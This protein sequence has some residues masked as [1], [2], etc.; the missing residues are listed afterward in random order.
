MPS[1]RHSVKIN[2][3]VEEVFAYVAD[4]ENCPQWR[5]GVLDIKRMNG[6][7]SVG[8]TYAQGVKG[9]MGRRIAADYMITSYE[10]N[11]ALEFQTVAGPARPHGRYEFEQTN[12][13]TRLNFSLDA[14]LGA[15]AGLF[16]GGMVQK[17]MDAEVRAIERLKE[18]LEASP[19]PA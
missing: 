15:I 17:T 3:P 9:P 14:T 4:G 10:P 6:D 16:M 5:S 8:T 11:R 7:G 19:T 1:A 18:V 12:G 2:R 13:T